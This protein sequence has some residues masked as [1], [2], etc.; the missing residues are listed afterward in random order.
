MGN[1][2]RLSFVPLLCVVAMVGTLGTRAAKR[3][4]NPPNAVRGE[5][6]I[7]GFKETAD[8]QDRPRT[9]AVS[10]TVPSALTNSSF[11]CFGYVQ[12]G[13][14]VAGETWTFDHGGGDPFEGWEQIDNT[15]DQFTAF[16][17]INTA[18]WSGH[19]NPVVAPIINGAGSV[20][21]GLHQDEAYLLCYV[22]GLG[23]GNNWGQR[24]VS[25]SFTQ[26]GVGVATLQFRYWYDVESGF[27]FIKV[28]LDDMLG[29][30]LL[31][32]ITGNNGTPASPVVFNMS[33][34]PALGPF[35]IRFDMTSDG[36][37]SDE[38]GLYT[39]V[40]GAFGI[41]DV[42]VFGQSITVVPTYTFSAS[43]QGFSVSPIPGVGAISSI[44]SSGA[45]TIS[46]SVCGIAGNLV[47]FH[48]GGNQ[49]PASQDEMIC[50][51]VVDLTAYSGALNVFA[52][53]DIYRQL[54]G[55]GVKWT[56]MF[57]YY[58]FTCPVTGNP[59]WSDP[60]GPG[61]LFYNG[62]N[63]DCERIR[64]HANDTTAASRYASGTTLVPAGSDSLK[65]YLQVVNTSGSPMGNVTPLFDNIRIC[66]SG[67][68]TVLHVPSPAYPNIQ[69][70]IDVAGISDTI[71][72]APG[73]YAGD[74]NRALDFSGKDLA[75]VSEAGPDYTTIDPEFK[76]R[77]IQFHNGE[78]INAVF[79][80]F[81]FTNVDSIAPGGGIY[82]GPTASY[83]TIRDCKVVS[84]A[85]NGTNGVVRVDAGSPR[86]QCCVV[87]LNTAS[88]FGAVVRVT[89]GGPSFF[90]SEFSNNVADGACVW[91][92][93]GSPAFTNCE[94]SDNV[95]SGTAGAGVWVATGASFTKCTIASNSDE[96]MRFFSG[97]APSSVADCV[98]DGN[99]GTGIVLQ[100]NSTSFTGCGITS[101]MNG[102]V[103]IESVFSAASS[104][105]DVEA[106]RAAAV[107]TDPS[108][109]DCIIAGNVNTS[110]SGGGILYDCNNTPITDFAP[111][112]TNVTITGNSS[113]LDGGGV[114]VCGNA[115]I[116]NIRPEFY[117]CSIAANSAG[118]LGGGVYVNVKVSGAESVVLF[119]KSIV[120][121]N[122]A[123]SA[124]PDVY[125]ESNNEVSF[126]CS[127]VDSL[128]FAGGGHVEF[129][130][131]MTFDN[132]DFCDLVDCASEGTIKGDFSLADTS[133]AIPDNSPCGLLIGANSSICVVSG[134][135]DI[136]NAPAESALFQNA[137][138]PFNPT[139]T[140]R[141]DLDRPQHVLMRVYD[142]RGRLVRHL[143]DKRMPASQ[144]YVTWHGRNDHGEPV[145]T[146]VYFLQVLAGDLHETRKMVLIK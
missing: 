52:E 65:F 119:D 115:V 7:A 136:P 21:L 81:T 60:A 86:F 97:V 141:F 59:I 118:G 140:I 33:F 80:G 74:G 82:V 125:T 49:H 56:W 69:S 26:N 79:E 5:L 111:V 87:E 42:N 64:S 9:A 133:S 104:P 47:S 92:S 88:D 10:C 102:G 132:P 110:S 20:W 100:A 138:N 35:T 57:S 95:V 112:C 29:S 71:I 146:G 53:Y 12:S 62:N 83:A 105:D 70:A 28:Y 107:I 6:G 131:Q 48:N 116:A 18:K 23:Y 124:G 63:P 101:N 45:Y 46:D 75:V 39:T 37:L 44:N 8:R 128:G 61:L 67:G 27:D 134:A 4:P 17:H 50:S 14:A 66:V 99:A 51:P 117:N 122:C 11:R 3:L 142:V 126:Q 109:E 98:I 55:T 15:T 19:G 144:H 31:S 85:S 113:A 145:A 40:R 2:V 41:D 143:V 54:P 120:W 76:T 93:G 84:N 94:V 78:S 106:A 108:F 30:S 77:G 24:L 90:E 72:V 32:T 129:G 114:A 137:P 34:N 43:L 13:L 91:L 36:M 96:G 139:T 103:R 123:S 135:G 89:G 127:D 58:P 121:G 38:D 1:V 68:S 22:D 73:T 16:R 130:L 25:P